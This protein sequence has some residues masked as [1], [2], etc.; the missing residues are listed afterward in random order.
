MQK[1]N[2]FNTLLLSFLLLIPGCNVN[3]M[4]D[5]NFISN[6]LDSKIVENGINIKQASSVSSNAKYG[7]QMFTYSIYPE[8]YVDTIE[9]SLKYEDGSNVTNNILVVNHDESN[10]SF[11]IECHNVFT[12]SINLK[13]YSSFNNNVNAT[14]KLDFLEKLSYDSNFVQNEGKPLSISPVINST[15]G[16]I[17][18]DKTITNEKYTWNKNFVNTLVNDYFIQEI[19]DRGYILSEGSLG[20]SDSILVD[21]EQ[22]LSY[23]FRNN[24]YLNNFL[25]DIT[26]GW[27]DGDSGEAIIFSLLDFDHYEYVLYDECWNN[28]IDYTYTCNGIV[29][30]KSYGIDIN[31]NLITIQSIT[32]S[33]NS[34]IVF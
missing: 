32:L 27:I 30:T 31:F 21:D 24:F 1:R 15:G 8:R 22:G 3:K 13:L 34:N 10:K 23:Y 18:V 5:N 17:L 20:M 11:T 33:D 6:Q 25:S 16:T 14:I 2:I 29:Y 7:A 4:N 9:Y 12:K 26:F 19:E 28:V